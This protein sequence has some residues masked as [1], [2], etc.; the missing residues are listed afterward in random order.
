MI[1][2]VGF[3]DLG[4]RFVSHTLIKGSP[5]GL[6]IRVSLLLSSP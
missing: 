5:E 2:G 6:H 4:I 1:Q 3:L